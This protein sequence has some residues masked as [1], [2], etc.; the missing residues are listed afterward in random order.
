MIKSC[1]LG[2]DST[3]SP[4]ACAENLARAGFTHTF[5]MWGFHGEGLR[6]AA[7][8]SAAGLTVETVHAS[9]TGINDIWLDN[10][11]GEALADY[12]VSCIR[13]TAAI[14]VHT[15]ILHLSSG[16]RP[17]P[18]GTVGLRR[19]ERICREAERLGVAVAFENLRKI[20]YLQYLFEHLDSPARKFCYDCGHENLYDGGDGVLEQFAK[21]LV[22]VHL[23]DNFGK[24]DE[25]LLPFVG[26]IDWNRLANRLKAIRF[27]LPITLELKGAG[28]GLPCAHAAFAAASH[29][30]RLLTK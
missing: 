24:Q 25:H 4:T 29:L 22:A 20:A 23:H 15:V 16:D 9:F 11:Q 14:G 13:G 12:F 6:A 19:Y 7:A 3:L 10:L 1:N 8:A 30:E 21:D 28:G 18:P 5:V 2:Y 26:V 17:P 27:S